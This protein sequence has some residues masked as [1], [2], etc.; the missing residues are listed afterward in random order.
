MDKLEAA[1]G[2]AVNVG[3]EVAKTVPVSV[4]TE[5]AQAGLDKQH[6]AENKAEK[7]QTKATAAAAVNYFRL[8]RQVL[9]HAA[10]ALRLYGSPV[11]ASY[12]IGRNLAHMC[13]ALYACWPCCLTA[14][15]VSLS[16]PVDAE[17]FSCSAE[18]QRGLTSPLWHSVHLAPLQTVSWLQTQP[19]AQAARAVQHSCPVSPR[20]CTLH[21]KN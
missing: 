16:A 2:V 1:N 14:W 17:G 4:G 7:L 13:T 10:V 6:V 11:A 21:E 12:T 8:Y 20:K 15:L 18:R 3:H 19:Y 9:A 5:A